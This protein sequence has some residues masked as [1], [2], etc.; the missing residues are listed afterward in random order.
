MSK[1]VSVDS[2]ELQYKAQAQ[3]HLAEARRIL[4]QLAADRQR[5]GRRRQERRQTS[6]PSILSEVKAILEHA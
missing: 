3:N 6:R 4:R 2:Q 5:E 1:A